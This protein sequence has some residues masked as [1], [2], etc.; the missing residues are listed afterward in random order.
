M[1]KVVLSGRLTADPEFRTT[2]QTEI[3]RYRL[4]VDKP[5]S[6]EADFFNVVCFGKTA[7]FANNYLYKGIKVIV[8]GRLTSGSYKDKD[9]RTVYRV[10]VVAEEHEFAEPKKRIDTGG[11]MQ[12]YVEP[13]FANIPDE[14][15]VPFA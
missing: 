15:G 7:L 11:E 14:E 5:R 1:N 2:Q 8:S 3:A 4:A 10:D 12:G 6:K 13:D 9:G